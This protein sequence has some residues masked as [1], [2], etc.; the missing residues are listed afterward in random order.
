[1]VRISTTKVSVRA[2]NT[3]APAPS[4]PL[5]MLW[6]ELLSNDWILSSSLNWSLSRPSN[7]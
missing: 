7:E 4:T 5:A 2:L 6:L 1:M 3:T